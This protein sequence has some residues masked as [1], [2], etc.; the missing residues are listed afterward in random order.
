MFSS[1]VSVLPDYFLKK[2][3]WPCGGIKRN[4]IYPLDACPKCIK[5]YQNLVAIVLKVFFV[6]IFDKIVG[7]PTFFRVTLLLHTYL[8]LQLLEEFPPERLYW[9]FL[10]FW[11]RRLC[12]YFFNLTQ[13]RPATSNEHQIVNNAV[14]NRILLQTT[15]P[16]KNIW[17]I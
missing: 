12:W 14:M 3:A 4:L 9:N 7:F 1:P 15:R 8:C 2:G 17:Y 6:D 5:M 13:D 16:R 10:V 11:S